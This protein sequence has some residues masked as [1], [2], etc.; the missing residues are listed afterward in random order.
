M[1]HYMSIH[2]PGTA[3]NKGD[4]NRSFEGKEACNFWHKHFTHPCRLGPKHNCNLFPLDELGLWGF[5]ESAIHT[6]NVLHGF[7]HWMLSFWWDIRHLWSLSNSFGS[8]YYA[9][10]LRNLPTIGGQFLLL[11]RYSIFHGYDL[12]YIFHCGT[13]TWWGSHISIIQLRH[14]LISLFGKIT[15]AI[16][17]T[18]LEK[19]YMVAVARAVGLSVAGCSLPWLLKYLG[20]WK[21]FHQIIFALPFVFLLSPPWVY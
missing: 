5:L 10:Y 4:R 20:D 15:S 2:L 7:H 1:F 19:R 6:I 13:D 11:Y 9:R 18:P 16:E 3:W 17:N 21:M 12:Q 8:Q 14:W